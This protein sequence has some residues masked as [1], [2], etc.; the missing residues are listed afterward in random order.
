LIESLLLLLAV[1]P[2]ALYLAYLMAADRREPEPQHMILFTLGLGILSTIPA[3]LIEGLLGLIPV[4][5]PDTF[6]GAALASFVQVA[7]VE[8]LCKLVAV[9]AFAWK[10]A[11]FNE[12]N[13]GI[14]Y[15]TTGAIG[16][17]LFEN[18]LYVLQYGFGTGIARALTSIPLHVFCGVIMGY[19]AGKARF[20]SS[21]R[22]SAGFL[23]IGFGL[24][25]FIHG[26]YDTFA[27]S[28]GGA[29]PVIAIVIALMAV[30]RRLLLAGSQGSR[31][32]WAAPDRAKPMR[33]DTPAEEFA[34]VVKKYGE[35]KIGREEDGR[36][37]LKPEKQVWKAAIGRLFLFLSV[38]VVFV[39]IRF[40]GRIPITADSRSALFAF[41][42]LLT[43]I[44]G[45]LGLMLEFSYR[46]R[47]S[48]RH[49]FSL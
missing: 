2:P 23:A 12:E 11:N 26:A 31:E 44:P 17:A 38:V 15:V 8:E 37:Y 28:G 18:I 39:G 27:M 9:L 24:A 45:V 30:G 25:W 19:F 5:S 33:L 14:V 47:A 41:F 7:P 29:L 43:A 49:Y 34:R 21:R 35:S 16:F 46:R 3:M 20:A 4:F 13:D 32:R 6:G 1:L 36:Y 40:P 48:T 10:N 42:F 22:E